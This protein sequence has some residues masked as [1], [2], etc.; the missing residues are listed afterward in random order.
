VVAAQPEPR[1]VADQHQE[2]EYVEKPK[3]KEEPSKAAKKEKEQ[4]EYVP[5]EE[6]RYA[7]VI[8]RSEPK[9]KTPVKKSM[10]APITTK[11]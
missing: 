8:S 2:D 1:A 6:F 4:Q 5:S 3:P 9:A 7:K 11:Q 10:S